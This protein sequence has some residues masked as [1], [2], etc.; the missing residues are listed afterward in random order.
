MKNIIKAKYVLL[1]LVFIF[2]IFGW[3]TVK[4]PW[5]S[6]SL[7]C[8]L[9]GEKF[10]AIKNEY[11]WSDTGSSNLG[12]TIKKAKDELEGHYIDGESTLKLKLSS[13]KNIKDFKVRQFAFDENGMVSYEDVTLNENTLALAE[14][15][16]E[17]IYSFV[18]TWDENH[19]VEY[20]LK[21]IL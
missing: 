21:I 12:M 5:V 15:Q 2:L 16:G 13:D 11:M 14:K 10:K 6:P 20:L 9:N 1:L 7:T 19:W 8:E 17:Y 4:I 3:S 18:A